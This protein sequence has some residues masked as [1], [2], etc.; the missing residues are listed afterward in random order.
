MRTRG[1]W[2]TGPEATVSDR[3]SRAHLW[4]HFLKF[5]YRVRTLRHL[6]LNYEQRNEVSIAAISQT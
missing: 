4:E 5:K 6:L 2:G 1:K 3:T